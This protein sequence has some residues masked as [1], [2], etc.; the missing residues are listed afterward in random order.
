MPARSAGVLIHRRLHAGIE[1]LLVHPGGPFWRNKDVGAWQI[2]KGLIDD[3]EDDEAAARREVGEE[4]GIAVTE[5]L[6]PLGEIRQAGGKAVVAF[7]LE[8]DV[9]TAAIVS[10]TVEIEWP[11]RSGRKLKIPEIDE[12]RWFGPEDAERYILTSQAPL[13]ERLAYR[14]AHNPDPDV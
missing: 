3:G 7:A 8:R 11:P 2:P 14:S 12:A 5:P 1:V 6:C 13:L 9:D 4:L 10:N